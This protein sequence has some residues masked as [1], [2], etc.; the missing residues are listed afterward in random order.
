MGEGAMDEIQQILVNEH[1]H[2]L[3]RDAD[4]GRLRDHARYGDPEDP[5]RSSGRAARVRLGQW[6]IGVGTTVAGSAGDRR[7]GTAGSAL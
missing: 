2:D 5:G 4:E 6:L 7:G 1:M 3:R